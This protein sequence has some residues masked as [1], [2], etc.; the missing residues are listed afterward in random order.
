MDVFG[1]RREGVTNSSAWQRQVN[2]SF[3][4]SL[5]CCAR[6]KI[7]RD[8]G[9]GLWTAGRRLRCV[10]LCLVIFVCT[11]DGQASEALPFLICVV[12]VPVLPA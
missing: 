10:A 5:S 3:H 7:R 11:L 2:T 4:T 9:R 6:T 8:F 1:L 12:R